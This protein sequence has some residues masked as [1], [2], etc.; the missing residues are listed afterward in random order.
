[1]R[2]FALYR[3][4][5][6]WVRTYA[7]ARPFLMLFIIGAVPNPVVDVAGFA[8]GRL[9]YSLPRFWFATLLGKSVRFIGVGLLGAWLL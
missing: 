7:A 6:S 4:V 9:G 3:R 2:R 1:M 5:E 8:A